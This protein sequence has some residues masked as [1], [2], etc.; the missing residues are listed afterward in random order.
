MAEHEIVWFGKKAG[1]ENRP[2]SLLHPFTLMLSNTNQGSSCTEKEETLTEQ[3]HG[4][5][6]VIY[7]NLI[8]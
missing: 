1:H 6:P 3:E 4:P 2:E 8:L 5:L 7:R